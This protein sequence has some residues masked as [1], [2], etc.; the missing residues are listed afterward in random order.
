MPGIGFRPLGYYGGGMVP[1]KYAN[2][3]L[4]EG[5]STMYG[6][7]GPPPVETLP[8]FQ[9]M[10]NQRTQN[11]DR[12]ILRD[13]YNV[14]PTTGGMTGTEVDR[15]PNSRSFGEIVFQEL[16]PGGAGVDGGVAQH[17]FEQFGEYPEG[18]QPTDP[19]GVVTPNAIE[20]AFIAIE[21]DPKQ[22][23]VKDLYSFLAR[24]EVQDA[25]R[26]SQSSLIR[27]RYKA[28]M[29]QLGGSGQI[30]DV[31]SAEEAIQGAG[32]GAIYGSTLDETIVPFDRSGFAGPFGG[33]Y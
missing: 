8:T 17:Y 33:Q 1:K 24:P 20:Q 18:Y 19:S 6:A 12:E 9:E 14:P 7:E 31:R 30:T 3:N 28:Y 25:L 4:V 27:E 26:N 13:M 5:D 2:G 10:L 32:T 21:D 11:Q 23:K 15:L 16:N 29:S 22:V